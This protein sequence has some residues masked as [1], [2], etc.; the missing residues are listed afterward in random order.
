MWQVKP[1]SAITAPFFTSLFFFFLSVWQIK[2][3]SAITAPYLPL[4]LCLSSRLKL[5][6]YVIGTI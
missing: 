2:L 1:A 6:D 3:A 5:K 4:S